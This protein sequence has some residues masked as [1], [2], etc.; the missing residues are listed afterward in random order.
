MKIQAAKAQENSDMEE[1]ITVI[2]PVYNTE[3]Q[4]ERCVR[5]IVNQTYE[6][7]E[8]LLVE[9]GSSDSSPQICERMAK[10]DNRIRVI[11][12]AN[13]G[14][15]D[16]RNRGLDEAKGK[17]IVFV[18]SDDWIEK[19]M[20][21]AM[22]EKA[23]QY[24]AP[25][26]ICDYIR[27]GESRENTENEKEKL[28]SSAQTLEIYLKE[29]EKL[30]IPHSVWGKLFLRELI[31]GKRFP[32]IKRTEELLFSTEIFC[33]MKQCVYLPQTFYHYCDDRAES[34][35]HQTDAV[36]TIKTEIP[37]LIKQVQEIKQ[38]GFADVAQLAWFCLGKRLMYI[39]LGFRDKML[40]QEMI[41]VKRYVKQ[42]RKEI[43]ASLRG[44]YGKKT[45][46]IRI[47]MFLFSPGV[48]YCFVKLHD[49]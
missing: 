8:I 32:L 49:K 43:F 16:A 38:A 48:Y 18:D 35:M 23:E 17:F 42:N 15:A 3:Q 36:H 33:E 6:K 29:D 25:L 37:L 45:D 21:A 1:L 27:S 5:S 41:A 2:V 46:K 34:L 9:D 47:G 12:K 22:I 4:L 13:G 14:V 11:R 30:R 31:G 39:Y 10:E 20:M 24:Q 7:M 44:K 26:V 19:D 40:R 28:L